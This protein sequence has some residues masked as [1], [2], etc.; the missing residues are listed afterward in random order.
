MYWDNQST[1]FFANNVV[2]TKHIEV[3]FHFIQDKLMKKQIVTHF[4]H[5]DD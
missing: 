1:I 5:L 3:D 4:V 2:F